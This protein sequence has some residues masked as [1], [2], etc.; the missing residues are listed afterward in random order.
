MSEHRLF[1]LHNLY[2]QCDFHYLIGIIFNK[3]K[4][5]YHP[6]KLNKHY[7]EIREKYNIFYEFMT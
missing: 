3:E 4:T 1:D 5:E 2:F 6:E 7:N